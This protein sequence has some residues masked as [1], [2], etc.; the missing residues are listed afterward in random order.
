[1]KSINMRQIL[2]DS[3]RLSLSLLLLVFSTF[4]ISS[5]QAGTWEDVSGVQIDQG[6]R[7]Y[8]RGVGYYTGNTITNVSGGDLNGPLR[9]VVTESS[10]VVNNADGTDDQGRP[11]FNALASAE[12][13]ANNQSTPSIRI[14]FQAR[15]AAFSYSTIVQ[16]YV[17]GPADSDNDGITDDQD[18]CPNDPGNL[19]ITIEGQV[20]GAGAL[21]GAAVSVAS[22][23][24][25]FTDAT[26]AFSL[27]TGDVAVVKNDGINNF[28]PLEVTAPGY[29]TG[30]VKVVLVPGQMSYQ[31]SIN[32]IQVSDTITN[33]DVLSNGVEIVSGGI[34]VG[35]L[36]IPDA[37]M[38]D[39]VTQITGTVTYL[40]P[41]SNDIL[42]A[43]GGDLL[44]L[45][46]G[47]DP[48]VDSP[49]PLESFG[50]MEFNLRDQNNNEITTLNAPAQVCMQA[51]SGLAQGDTVPLWYYDE[52]AGLWKEE[53]QGSVDYVNGRLMICGEVSHFTW[54]NYDRPVNTHSCFKFNFIDET[55]NTNITSL[56]WYAEGITYNG[57]A[58]ERACDRDA[59]D[60]VTGSNSISSLTV[61]R[62]TDS[63]NPEQIRV[64][65]VVNGSKFYLLSDGD[66]TYSLTQTQS[67]ATVF[68]N[69]AAN[70]SCLY[71]TDVENCQFLDYLDNSA[72]GILPLTVDINLPP[73]I[74]EFSVSNEALQPG[75]TVDVQAVVTDPESS[76]VS[77]SWTVECG[78]DQ[79]N[80]G[81]NI[82]PGGDGG[83]S[84]TLFSAQVTAPSSLSNPVESCRISLTATDTDGMS[85]TAQYW[86]YVVGSTM[87][88]FSGTLYGTDGQPLA[89]YTFD[90]DS[91]CADPASVQTDADGNYYLDVDMVNC[92]DSYG[93]YAYVYDLGEFLIN[94]S[95]DGR[96]WLRDEYL[97]N[98]EGEGGGTA[99][100][101]TSNADGT[102]CLYDIHLP[103][104]WGPL[105]GDILP[106]A[107]GNYTD[108][109]INPFN[110]FDGQSMDSLLDLIPLDNV[111]M[112]YGSI[113]L[114]VGNGSMTVQGDT[115]DSVSL[116]YSMPSEDGLV[117]DIGTATAP[118]TVTV[119]DDNGQPLPGVNITVYEGYWSSSTS[120]TTD[121]NG[122]FTL[123]MPLGEFYVYAA[124][125][126]YFWSG[127]YVT[128]ANQPVMVD[129][130]SQQ[131]C[132]ITGTAYDQYKVPMSNTLITLYDIE[133]YGNEY[134]GTT[135]I[136]GVFEIIG[137]PASGYLINDNWY[138]GGSEY[139]IDNCQPDSNGNPRQI[140]MD[141]TPNS[142]G[143]IVE[144]IGP[145]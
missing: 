45:P 107:S 38:P 31:L 60:P 108:L 86:V 68:D 62:T 122:Q 88:N 50:M 34:P 89:N 76:D 61:K 136:D 11:Y 1:M 28:I 66:G 19:C 29:A 44:A 95:Y 35:Q 40:D 73:L 32:L 106:P 53:G 111:T 18:L 14:E 126:S 5:A 141:Y 101:C 6:T 133:N 54:W 100:E 39:G 9:L 90:Y 47:A 87:Y 105:S 8:A 59:N 41:A 58:P 119:Y 130:N 121:P 103:I 80:S 42:A 36:T 51:G 145:S 83:S 33:E 142:S 134:S 97:S 135:D 74:T 67:G 79:N 63:N 37:A 91:N 10:H 116:L 27:Q 113:M 69:P 55:S 49:V 71:N 72:D 24:P 70:G 124:S 46:A 140:R 26:G 30:N 110:G 13:L 77:L 109:T 22:N 56:Y 94:Y 131:T 21:Q 23:R 12:V 93:Q 144:F 114:P 138:Y 15:R 117:Q 2:P 128:R 127:G 3:K 81:G 7:F 104:L 98:Y 96:D 139:Y 120:G 143:Q 125:P 20:F 43:P 78:Y 132:I 4:F 64:Y 75:E 99:L 52:A 65:T 129:L 84:G 17:E 16:Q 48:N 57:M 137:V 102:D 82:N 115:G 112:T 118:V 92:L 123:D 85:A 25:V